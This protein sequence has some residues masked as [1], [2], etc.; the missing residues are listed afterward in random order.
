MQMFAPATQFAAH[1][2]L[3]AVFRLS[4]AVDT[5]ASDTHS[6]YSGSSGTEKKNGG[7]GPPSQESER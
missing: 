4:A 7:G 5:N 2:L 6:S 1:S 3:Q